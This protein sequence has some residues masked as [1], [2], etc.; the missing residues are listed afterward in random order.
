M[1]YVRYALC[2]ISAVFYFA[3][4]M[5]R[6]VDSSGVTRDVLGFRVI[7][8]PLFFMGMHFW[9]SLGLLILASYFFIPTHKRP[10]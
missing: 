2:A 10:S 8:G 5:I 4:L 1:K 7:S 9:F 3:L 6:E